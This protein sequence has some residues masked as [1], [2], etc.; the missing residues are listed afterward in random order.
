MVRQ[1]IGKMLGHLGYQATFAKDGAEAI[2][3]Y[4]LAQESGT[5]FDAVILDLTV[6]GG[7]GGK[8]TIE[9]LLKI[10]PQVKA[11]VSSGYSHDSLIAEF[12]RYGFSG[13]IAKPYRVS[14]LSQVLNEVLSAWKRRIFRN[15][16]SALTQNL[17]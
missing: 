6:P 5:A 9:K 14:V 12:D 3:L 1:T 4:T 16:G 15:E 2:A 8:E 11:V 7:M 10:D 17:S 13:V